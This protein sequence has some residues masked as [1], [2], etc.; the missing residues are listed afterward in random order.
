MPKSSYSYSPSYEQKRET[1]LTKLNRK[2]ALKNTKSSGIY[3]PQ[4]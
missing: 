3:T 1:S 2:E 4:M